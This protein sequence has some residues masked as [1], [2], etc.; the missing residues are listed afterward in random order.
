MGATSGG[1]GTSAINMKAEFAGNNLTATVSF[2]RGS[3]KSPSQ[4]ITTGA[5]NGATISVTQTKNKIVVHP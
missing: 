1:K 5:Q 2:N 4:G 3:V